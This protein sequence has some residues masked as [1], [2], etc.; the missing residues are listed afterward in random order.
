MFLSLSEAAS[1]KDTF[2]CCIAGTGPAGLSLALSLG[3]S[4]RKIL[5]LEGGGD[6]WSEE[7][8]EIYSGQVIGD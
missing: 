6:E 3:Q 4:N 1:N 8:Q 7:S 5:L 2:D